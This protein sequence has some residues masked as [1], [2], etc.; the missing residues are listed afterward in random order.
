VWALRALLPAYGGNN[1]QGC[2]PRRGSSGLLGLLSI[3]SK[4]KGYGD[5]P[6]DRAAAAGGS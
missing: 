4:F 6:P 1:F 2:N 3:A 5:A